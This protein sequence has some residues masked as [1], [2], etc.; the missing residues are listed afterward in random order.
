MKR[1]QPLYSEKA[2]AGG[3]FVGGPL[4]AGIMM[5]RIF[6]NL[7]RESAARLSLIGGIVATVLLAFVSMFLPENFPNSV[8]P[9]LYCAAIYQMVKAY[10]GSSRL[11]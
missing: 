5:R 9:A 1:S 2:I 7:N 10:Q 6:L 4:A 8:L 3:A 11:E